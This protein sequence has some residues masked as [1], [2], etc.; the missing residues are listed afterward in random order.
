MASKKTSAL[1]IG[2]FLTFYTGTIVLADDTEI[3]TDPGANSG[4][5]PLVM[6]TI[7][8]SPSVLGSTVNCTAAVCTDLVNNGY[9]ES[10]TTTRLGMLQAVLKSLLN[11]LGGMKIGLMM[12][13]NSENNCAGRDET[14]ACS[15]GG[16]ILSG[17]KSITTDSWKVD[18]NKLAFF[19]LLDSLKTEV[20]NGSGSHTFQGK[21]VFFEFFRYLTGHDAYSS[22]LGWTDYGTDNSENLSSET[23][24]YQLMRDIDI[25]G[26]SFIGGSLTDADKTTNKNRYN[27]PGTYTSPITDDCQKIFTVNFVK[28]VTNQEDDADSAI[29]E[30][31]ANGGMDGINLSGKY[32]SLETVLEYLHA[33]DFGDGTWGKDTSHG[34]PDKQGLQNVT[35]FFVVDSSGLNTGND[36]AKAGGTTA[37]FEWTD[38][39]TELIDDLKD[40]FSQIISVSTTFTAASVPVSVLNRA[41]VIDNVFIA[42]FRAD[43]D[44]KK[45]WPGNV[46]R[47]YLDTTEG[48]LKDASSPPKN[49][50]GADGRIL[51]SALTYWTVAGSLPTADP[52]NNE[53]DGKDG[54]AVQRG[55]AGQIIP[56]FIS[57]TPGLSNS[58][59]GA[60]T[61]Y[62]EP[63]SGTALPAL[64]A[65]DTTAGVLQSD[66]GAA[67]VATAKTLIEYVRGLDVND[68]DSDTVTNEPRSWVLGDPL[69]SRPLPINY[70]AIN[71]ESTTVPDIRLL[72]GSNDGLL[73]MIRNTVSGSPSGKETWAFMPREVMGIVSD[74]KSNPATKPHP[75]GVDG[76][77]SAYYYDSNN[78]GKIEKT[79][80]NG[81]QVWVFFGL[82]RGGRGYYAL[83]ITDP[84]NPTFKWAITDDTDGDGVS[85]GDFAKLGYTFSQPRVGY[86]NWGLG[87]KPVVI[88]SGGYDTNKDLTSTD[89]SY[90]NALYVV[91]ADTGALV[92]K[93]V[94]GTTGPVSKTEYNHA[95]LDD[96]I[97]ST[98]SAIDTNSDGLLDRVYVGD[99]G[100]RVW[101]F[102]LAG[103]DRSNW[104]ATVIASVG[105]HFDASTGND[106]R[107]YHRPDFIQYKDNSDYDAVVIGSGNRAWPKSDMDTVNYLYVIKDRDTTS[108]TVAASTFNHDSFYDVTDNCLQDSSCTSSTAALTNGWRLKFE[109]PGEKVLATPTTLAKKI[110][111]T[112]YLPKGGPDAGTCAPKEGGGRLYALSLDDGTPVN[113]YNVENGDTLDK[114]DRYTELD[115]GGIP[116]EV[117]YVP[118]NRILK[119]DLSIEDVGVSGRWKT[120][121]YKKEN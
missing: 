101:R 54:R 14:S 24:K 21:E 95:D 25:E 60:R 89:D 86:M 17:F 64:N 34:A 80:A 67:D 18:S 83:D 47:L 115:S 66:L 61:L 97:P 55:G 110:F 104:K 5:E 29:T 63:S 103:T 72:F 75:Y 107:F 121:W 31:K 116:A 2:V 120:Y 88:F 81:D 39:P 71:G 111:V 35:S 19:S 118:F 68:A 82:R 49:A 113:D 30:S 53:I 96:S 65:D 42:L 33:V 74:L 32:N 76:A 43:P 100:G 98:V 112:T 109:E 10:T 117:V 105:R 93:A 91:D 92:W 58:D 73:H 4:G 20:T 57:G 22:H 11:D 85:D 6:F 62:Y 114:T 99:T 38:D 9:L 50:V 12:S 94:N 27:S 8:Y 3:Y 84:D 41:Q 7:D 51:H 70:G 90:G 56:G 108:G 46:K 26:I 37:A 48:L 87:K 45:R 23:D 102:D 119:P 59:T 13:H 15:G 52:A 44:N 78:D 69:H 40:I 1:L 28:G 77:P 106:R 79:D 16:Y 36:W